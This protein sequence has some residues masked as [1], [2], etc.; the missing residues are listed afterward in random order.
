[1]S[2]CFV[3][4]AVPVA[5]RKTLAYAVPE[6]LRDSVRVGMRV[7]APLGARKLTVGYITEIAA[8]SPPVPPNLMK[9]II[10]V[11][12]QE[13]LLTP[14]LLR[15]TK[16]AADYYLAPWGMM[17]K[18]A[19]PS[20]INVTSLTRAHITEAGR[21][22]QQAYAE[23]H[24]EP[25]KT[26][27]AKF[28]LL[29]FLDRHS[30]AVLKAV[31]QFVRIKSLSSVLYECEREGLLRLELVTRRPSVRE[32]KQ[33]IVSLPE[34]GANGHKTALTERQTAVLA[35]LRA[36]GGSE[37]L[38]YLTRAAH[39]STATVQSLAKKGCVRL[40][41]GVIA[42]APQLGAPIAVRVEHALTSDQQAV[43]T[44]VSQALESR[45]PARFLLHGVTGSGKTEV[46]ISLIA[47]ILKNGGSALM[48]VPEIALTPAMSQLFKA[49]FGGDVAIL[50]S[51][52]SEGE[53]LDEWW[54][55]RRGAARV[56]V[57]TRS[58]VFAPLRDLRLII[59][60]EEHDASY[61]QDDSPRYNGRDLAIKRS[62]LEGSV[63]L[64]G[65]ATPSLETYANATEK[66]KLEYLALHSRILGRPMAIVRIVDMC[67][68]F[69]KFGRAKIISEDLKEQINQRLARKE[70]V[71]IL[72]NR[73][74]YSRTVLCRSC[75][76]TIYCDH[77]SITLTWHRS[78]N[79]LI[80]HYCNATKPVPDRCLVCDKAFIYYIGEGTERIQDIMHE[81][82]PQARVDRMDYDTTRKKG[83]Y[84]EILARLARNETDILVGT[85]MIAKGHDFH[86][87]TLVG[88]IAADAGLSFPDFRT[89]ERTFQLITQVAG[90]AGRGETSGSV[91]I[92]TYY[93]NH[94]ALKLAC[95]QDY[96][97]F[98][99]EERRFRQLMHYPPFVALANIVVKDKDLKKVVRVA[100]KLANELRAIADHTPGGE[101]VRVMG[102]APAPLEKIRGEYR[103]QILIK[104][105]ER[106][107]LREVLERSAENMLKA[108]A[109]MKNVIIDID[110]VNIL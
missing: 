96:K 50:H 88:V 63:V 12:D 95:R 41:K 1:M 55:I 6:R 8:D 29:A 72:L 38:A 54:R 92:Q 51:G 24:A 81:M 26:A 34:N 98:Y 46:Y 21:A 27:P 15:L 102:P 71:L 91:V 30:P 68:E 87:V 61:K 25:K 80:C 104:S 3:H 99:Q 73:R 7:L 32:K 69:M 103:Y 59:V 62:A 17:L 16:W 42:R 93:P 58:A 94:Y 109:G 40:V 28:R 77:C 23:A 22:L 60:D 64:L 18:A 39:C 75:G 31:H 45:R 35:R 19:L 13:P 9:D 76:T 101:S 90:R 65:S 66:K 86:N 37:P 83:R 52:L 36:V 57:G 11:L 14:E 100:E 106:P 10:D 79:Q 105:P 84:Q 5:V 108:K 44:P 53:R 33:W 49:V 70:Q 20:G 56:A 2:N 4:V 48:L 82:F 107:I 78:E 67:D 74:G 97:A 43:I 85:Q 110:P 47:E 89:A